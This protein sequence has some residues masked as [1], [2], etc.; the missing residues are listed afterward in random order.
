MDA[1][2]NCQINLD[3][4]YPP[5]YQ[6]SI[7]STTFRGFVGLDDN[8]VA[9][10]GALYYFSGRELLSSIS[11]SSLF[12]PVAPQQTKPPLK[13]RQPST[14]RSLRTIQSLPMLALSLSSGRRV[15]RTG[16]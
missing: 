11:Q 4:H 9:T 16:R 2:K 3:L 14:G 5:G 10:L 7:L 6:F 8:V 15:V 1:R 13:R 12:N